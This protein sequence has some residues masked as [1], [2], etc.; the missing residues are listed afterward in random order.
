M[1][2]CAGVAFGMFLILA[3][4]KGDQWTSTDAFCGATCH[5]MEAH[6]ANEPVYLNSVHRTTST[7]IQA[8]CG[9][10]HIPKG[11][12]DATWTHIVAGTRDG[13]SALIH[14]FS[15]RAAWEARRADMAHLVRDWML[16]NDS[17]P[18]RSCHE[19]EALRPRRERGR[20]QH[21]L[22]ERQG[23][24]C[25]GCHFNLVHDPVRPR[26][27]FLQKVQVRSVT[28]PVAD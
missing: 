4:E 18:C 22:A 2:G 7:G 19:R 28:S 5:A 25:I 8:G 20:R 21:E 14:D 16:A 11:L 3:L 27:S 9:D 26:Q 15:T 12:I 13:Y 24:T 1:A 10:C 6:V 17:A 23:I